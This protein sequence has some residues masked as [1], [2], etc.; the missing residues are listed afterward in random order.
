MRKNITA[1]LVVIAFFV[2]V[3]GCGNKEKGSTS[4]SHASGSTKTKV[5][6]KSDETLRAECKRSYVK[7][8]KC[9]REA[10]AARGCYAENIRDPRWGVQNCS[11]ALVAALDDCDHLG[12]GMNHCEQY[13]D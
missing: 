7:F 9:T 11:D 3:L 4:S 13:L 8:Q 5:E 2:L 10:K 1:T 12:K 6:I